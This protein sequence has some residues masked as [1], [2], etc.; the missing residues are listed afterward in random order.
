MAHGGVAGGGWRAMVWPIAVLMAGCI[1]NNLAL[2][3]IVS[4]R[5]NPWADPQAGSL[6]TMLHF[7]AVGAA[8]LPQV[9]VWRSATKLALAETRST[10]PLAHAAP[11]PTTGLW[12]SL[13]FYLKPTVVPLREYATMTLLF[14]AMS[15][16]NNWAFAWHISQPLHMVFRSANLVTT[17]VFGYL[18]FGRE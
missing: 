11:A 13:P 2:E 6:L 16:A 10:L 3:L 9:I 18:W 1:V 4:K 15:L 12:A 5:S 8:N 7:L 14:S 17:Y